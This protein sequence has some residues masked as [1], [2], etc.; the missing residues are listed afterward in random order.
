MKQLNGDGNLNIGIE[1]CYNTI[2]LPVEK[3]E[4]LLS[5][6]WNVD[7]LVG[8]AMRMKTVRIDHGHYDYKNSI[9][10]NLGSNVSLRIT[11]AAMLRI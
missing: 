5:D 8:K 11:F 7:V 2:R 4:K 6:V 3:S 1:E 9:C 10:P